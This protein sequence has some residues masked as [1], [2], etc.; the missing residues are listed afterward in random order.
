MP[1]ADITP[2][3]RT[4]PRRAFAPGFG[5]G[6]FS[7]A[8]ANSLRPSEAPNGRDSNAGA[9]LHPLSHPGSG[10][11]V[12]GSP[13]GCSLASAKSQAAS[14]R[15]RWRISADSERCPLRASALRAQSS[16]VRWPAPTLCTTQP[17]PLG[18]TPT[19]RSLPTTRS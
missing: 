14:M 1:S 19:A 16:V 18:Y 8:P 15:M 13:A 11:A 2:A 10:L 17:P 12:A 9:T 4:P 5:P 7:P 6:R 3:L